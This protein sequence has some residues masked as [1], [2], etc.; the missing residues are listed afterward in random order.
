MFSV[1]S[2][3]CLDWPT[4]FLICTAQNGHGAP[5]PWGHATDKLPHVFCK[6]N[7]CLSISIWYVLAFRSSLTLNNFQLMV[8]PTL[9]TLFYSSR[10]HNYSACHYTADHSELDIHSWWI[11]L[12]SSP[13][14]ISN[15]AQWFCWNPIFRTNFVSRRWLKPLLI[16]DARLSQVMF[17]V[18]VLSLF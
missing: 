1:I 15:I 9:E 18:P 8:H 17:A 12:Y 4:F 7:Y 6:Q 5:S 11:A 3:A 16:T 2:V 10:D 13:E 14:N